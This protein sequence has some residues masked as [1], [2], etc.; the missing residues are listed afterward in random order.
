VISS[1]G[2]VLEDR[3]T[4]GLKPMKSIKGKIDIPLNMLKFNTFLNYNSQMGN[5]LCEF[6]FENINS[7]LFNKIRSLK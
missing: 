1:V 7:L 2:I 3:F 6:V 4:K 5:H